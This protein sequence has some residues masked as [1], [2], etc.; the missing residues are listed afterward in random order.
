MMPPETPVFSWLGEDVMTLQE[1]A[2]FGLEPNG[3]VWSASPPPSED[4]R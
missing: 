3:A 4:R 1:A 2:G